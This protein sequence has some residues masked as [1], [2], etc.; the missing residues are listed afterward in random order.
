MEQNA[1]AYKDLSWKFPFDEE[2]YLRTIRSCGH[3]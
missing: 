1:I 3:N 2:F